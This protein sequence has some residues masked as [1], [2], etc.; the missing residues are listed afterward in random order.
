[1]EAN[2]S[3]RM[4]VADTSV[5]LRDLGGST[6][7]TSERVTKPR[8]VFHRPFLDDHVATSSAGC[9]NGDWKAKSC[10]SDLSELV[11][12]FQTSEKTQKIVPKSPL[13]DDVDADRIRSPI[14]NAHLAEI[15][16][17]D[18]RLSAA[19]GLISLAAMTEPTCLN[20]EAGNN[21][22]LHSP[23]AGMQIFCFHIL[24]HSQCRVP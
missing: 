4:A 14:V 11:H 9:S 12:N 16:T 22:I 21:H 13:R 7:K 2:L 17:N 10:P 18:G 6:S 20:T 8:P 19:L 3:N 5:M 23:S 24:P 15:P 1:M